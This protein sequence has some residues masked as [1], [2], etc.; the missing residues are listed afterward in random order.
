MSRVPAHAALSIRS[1]RA[2]DGGPEVGLHGPGPFPARGLPAPS[3][4]PGR[5][6]PAPTRLHVDHG[7]RAGHRSQETTPGPE[8]PYSAASAY[9]HLR[10]S[11]RR[12]A[13]MAATA[14]T[15]A[16]RA[17]AMAVTRSAVIHSNHATGAHVAHGGRSQSRMVRGLTRT[18]WVPPR[19]RFRL[20]VWQDRIVVVLKAPQGPWRVPWPPWLGKLRA[21]QHDL[22]GG[23]QQ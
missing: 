20:V 13:A 7:I 21:G 18:R 14:A 23:G 4:R 10:R 9:G 11:L 2:L 19:R 3:I 12:A 1:T 6:D 15:K 16:L 8:R 17:V 5:G 22:P